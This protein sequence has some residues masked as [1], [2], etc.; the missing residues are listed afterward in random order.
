M[1]PRGRVGGAAPPQYGAGMTA[2]DEAAM[3]D[4]EHGAESV[5]PSVTYTRTGD[6][7][8]TALGDRSRT[9]KADL[10]IAAYGACE[11]A[12]ATIGTAISF[13]TALP[14]PVITLLVRVQ[15]DLLD[16]GAD[17]CHPIGSE[18]DSP[19]LRIDGH[20]VE[21]LER[22]CDHFN[23]QLPPLPSFLLPGGAANAAPL[24]QA[25]TAVRAAER[26][27]WAAVAEHGESMNPLVGRYLNRLSSLL[28]ILGR[29]ANAE[30][31]DTLWQPGFT[32]FHGVELWE[33]VVAEVS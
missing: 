24:F 6:D 26:T 13:G 18:F 5:A 8:S 1:T 30:H 2:H 15:N 28:F 19:A 17:L 27:T 23:Q 9:G 14:D 25:R 32:G 29:L 16:L 3:L 22:A 7:G 20:Y 12:S 21:R 10:R 31:G 4:R 11:E 33:D